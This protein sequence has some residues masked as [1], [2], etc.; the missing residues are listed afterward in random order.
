MK[1]LMTVVL[2]A[3]LLL[4]SCA[5]VS[6]PAPQLPDPV[7]E[8]QAILREKLIN[9]EL[10][11]ASDVSDALLAGSPDEI[12]EA[13]LAEVLLPTSLGITLPKLNTKKVWGH[14]EVL[15]SNYQEGN[16]PYLQNLVDQGYAE[17][18]PTKMT[19][20]EYQLLEQTWE[21]SDEELLEMVNSHPELKGEDFT[22]WTKG[23]KKAYEEQ[24]EQEILVESLTEEQKTALQNRNILLEDLPNLLDEYQTVDAVL[25]QSDEELKE[26]LED[27]YYMD[28]EFYLGDDVSETLLETH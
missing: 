14:R 4:C 1:R 25:Q 3:M 18:D 24:L 17:I 22:Q 26:L 8:V 2:I 7:E 27:Y 13:V 21:L 12:H 10:Y 28:L 11:V 16:G 5:P 15:L 23:Q 6:D 19:Y 20:Q 9:G